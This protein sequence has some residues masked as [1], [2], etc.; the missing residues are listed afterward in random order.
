MNDNE[1]KC[2]LSLYGPERYR[3]TRRYVTHTLELRNYFAIE[4]LRLDER[5]R[6]IEILREIYDKIDGYIHDGLC[7]D[8]ETTRKTS[9]N[10]F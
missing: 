6:E 9:Q 10:I 5:E 3:E 2:C 8:G 7:A 4:R 1:E